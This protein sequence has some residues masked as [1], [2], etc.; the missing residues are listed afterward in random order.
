M[1]QLWV[2]QGGGVRSLHSLFPKEQVR[3]SEG[4]QRALGI[5]PLFTPKVYFPEN[6]LSC[7]THTAQGRGKKKVSLQ[8]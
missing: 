4:V 2:Q 5:L 8:L 1:K 6:L 7:F 3:S